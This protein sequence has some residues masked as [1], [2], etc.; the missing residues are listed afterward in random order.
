MFTKQDPKTIKI[1]ELMSLV[2]AMI[3]DETKTF[4]GSSVKV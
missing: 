3:A 4:L 1:L 2:G